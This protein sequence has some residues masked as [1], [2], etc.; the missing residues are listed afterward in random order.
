VTERIKHFYFGVATV[1]LSMATVAFAGG[2]HAAA[3]KIHRSGTFLLARTDEPRALDPFILADDGSFNTV[4]HDR[5][6][7]I[8]V[9]KSVMG[10]ESGLTVPWTVSPGHLIY[11]S[12]LAAG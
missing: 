9:D 12:S 2:G 5:E 11:T 8:L 3:A 1:F 4:A 10:R 7:L 6:S